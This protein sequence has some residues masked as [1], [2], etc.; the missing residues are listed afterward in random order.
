MGN[1]ISLIR[2]QRI[3]EDAVQ[4]RNS[5]GKE[6]HSAHCFELAVAVANLKHSLTSFEHAQRLDRRSETFLASAANL[7]S[8]NRDIKILSTANEWILATALLDTQCQVGN[9]ISRRLVERLGKLSSFSTEFVPPEV[10]EASGGPVSACGVI[11]LDWKWHPQ[12]TRNHVCQFYVFPFSSHLDVLFWLNELA[13]APLVKHKKSKKEDKAAIDH[14]KR[15][16]EEKAA[17]EERR[18][19]QQQG[20]SKQ[21]QSQSGS[22]QW[23]S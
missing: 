18:K 15:Q 14:A 1:V 13:L 8:F 2:K 6:T 20:G 23:S 11:D 19:Q 22:Q 10:V 9:W 16:Q 4:T 17:L 21:G 12:A 7:M 3:M 5:S